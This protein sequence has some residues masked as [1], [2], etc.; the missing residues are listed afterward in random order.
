MSKEYVAG[1]SV[2]NRQFQ[3]G[4]FEI[5]DQKRILLHSE[6]HDRNDASPFWFLDRIDR[7][8]KIFKHVSK[9]SVALDSSTVIVHS[10]PIDTS[11]TQKEQQEHVHWEFSNIIVDYQP[12]QY[13][14]DIHVLKTHVREQTVEVLAVAVQRQHIVD[15]QK[16]ITDRGLKVGLIDT[17]YFASEYSL[18]ANYSEIKTKCVALAV[19]NN[20]RV[21][22]GWYVNGRLN[23]FTSIGS[24]HPEVMIQR[25]QNKRNEFSVSEIFYCG[26]VNIIES[27]RLKLKE[28][29]I[30][31]TVVDPMRRLVRK[32]MWRTS[33]PKGGS[34]YMLAACAGIAL[35]SR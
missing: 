19:M 8:S 21:E 5:R 31:M 25:I 29:G 32:S 12:Q 14:A 11:L 34:D 18:L 1:I 27:L 15:M 2:G 16:L 26:P 22:I 17:G 24:P 30:P 35:Q 9:I 13:V 20:D 33:R 3:I 10:F 28:S 7:S 4:V 23:C 6:I